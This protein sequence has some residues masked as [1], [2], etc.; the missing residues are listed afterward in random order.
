M[1]AS[2]LERDIVIT[3]PEAIE[4]L[5]EIME[6]EPPKRPLSE[7]PYNDAERERSVQLLKKFVSRSGN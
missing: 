6:S 1:A 4:K 3:D 7:H 2:I 5:Y